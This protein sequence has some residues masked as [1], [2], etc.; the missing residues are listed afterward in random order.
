M[1]RQ[2]GGRDSRS[3]ID[4]ASLRTDRSVDGPCGLG[5]L[6][7]RVTFGLDATPLY[8]EMEVRAG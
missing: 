7:C 4:G 3:W 5:C 8:R 1:A 6:R 2:A